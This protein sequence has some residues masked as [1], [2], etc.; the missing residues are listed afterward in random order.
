MI[1]ISRNKRSVLDLLELTISENFDYELLLC[2]LF[3]S[4]V[5]PSQQNVVDSRGQPAEDD[6]QNSKYGHTLENVDYWD[7]ILEDE[8]GFGH[9]VEQILEISRDFYAVFVATV[10]MLPWSCL[11]P[12]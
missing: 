7:D 3:D 8:E 2:R 4:T 10:V 9:N 11:F 6:H 12:A 1:E 5:A